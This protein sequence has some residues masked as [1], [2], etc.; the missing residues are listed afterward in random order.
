MNVRIEKL[1]YGGEGLGYAAGP[2]PQRAGK[3][4]FVPFVLPG[5]IVAVVP[6]QETRKLIRALPEKILEAAADRV[7][8]PCPYFTHCGGCH[9][10]HL[11]YE[12]EVALKVEIL[13]ETLRR[14]GGI[15]WPGAIP[16]ATAAP[17]DY[18]NRIQLQL[19]PHPVRADRLQIGYYR[20]GSHTLCGVEQCP[21]SSPRLN[22]LICALQS[23]NAAGHLPRRLRQVEAFVTAEDAPGWLTLSAPVLDFAPDVLADRL[24]SAWP[25]VESILF[26]ETSSGQRVLVGSGGTRYR[27]GEEDLR[28]SH[29]AFFQVNRYL[30]P[31][32]VARV[33]GQLAGT[34]A[35][36]LYA[37]VGLFAR[38]LARCF[39]RV[40]AV[41]AD[42]DTA[43]DLAAN[44]ATLANLQPHCADAGAF[45]A[46]W[47]TPVDAA[48]LDPP[49]TGLSKEVVR[50]LVRV[51]PRAVVYLSCD[52]ATL[53]RD[54]KA[55]TTAFRIESFELIDLFPQTF[56]IET[57]ARLRAD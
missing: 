14:L 55:L 32:V 40:A 22:E 54:V 45:L 31:E 26:T 5:E 41:E 10:Q 8:P 3:P 57:L 37:G 15:D 4:V 12:Q 35:L 51:R 33:Q 39:E 17:W 28:V 47:R 13:R 23:L 50:E 21:I 34:T 27:V 48:V 46:D 24:R 56:H 53:A 25:G 18:R 49:R 20:Q 52:P 43:A 9:Y 30:L 7:E 1:V 36:D 11:S 29:N 6:T 2:P 44:T 16:A 38:H 42:A 19:G